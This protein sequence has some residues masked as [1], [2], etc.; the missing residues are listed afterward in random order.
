MVDVQ[1]EYWPGCGHLVNTT[2]MECGECYRALIKRVAELQRSLS[3][4]DDMRARWNELVDER[5]RLCKV[6][7]VVRRATS[8][9]DS[10]KHTPPWEE[11]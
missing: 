11:G 1:I 10:E 5:D 9:I 4:L 7:E 3:T 6:V 2:D 8:H